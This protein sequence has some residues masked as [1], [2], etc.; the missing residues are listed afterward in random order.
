MTGKGLKK[1]FWDAG[2]LPVL[3]LDSYMNVFV[4]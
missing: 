3:E 4:L 2:N 1:C